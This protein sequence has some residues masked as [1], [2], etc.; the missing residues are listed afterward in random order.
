MAQISYTAKF[1]PDDALAEILKELTCH[2]CGHRQSDPLP[3]PTTDNR[4]RIF[5]DRFGTF[6]TI[7]LSEEQV[8]AMQPVSVHG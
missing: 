4:L 8:R 6:T 3:R 1:R 5:R 2:A 7:L